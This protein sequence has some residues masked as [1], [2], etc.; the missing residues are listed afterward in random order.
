MCA[1]CVTV[2][3]SGKPGDSSRTLD[4]TPVMQRT[5]MWCWLTVGEMIFRYYNVNQK[6]A[7]VNYQCDIVQSVFPWNCTPCSVCQLQGAAKIQ[8]IQK[9]LKDYPV[10]A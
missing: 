6:N 8:N 2:Q 1:V 4:I 9:M 7:A 10:Q 5:L 3:G